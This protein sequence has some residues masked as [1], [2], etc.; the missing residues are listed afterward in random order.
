MSV[1]VRKMKETDLDRVARL[2]AE[3]FNVN[4]ERGFKEAREH[5]EDHFNTV[6]EYCYVVEKDGEVVGTLV[7]HPQSEVFE[8]ENF[9]VKDLEQNRE[10]AIKLRETLLAR[11]KKIKITVT[12][13]PI[14]LRRL[15]TL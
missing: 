9:H 14:N 11:L 4:L 1:K 13:C 15:L 3:D 5:T 2:L 6:P 12:S 8:I 10:A 7:L